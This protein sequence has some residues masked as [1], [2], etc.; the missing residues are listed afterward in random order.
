MYQ[1]SSIKGR[2]GHRDTHLVAVIRGHY[3]GKQ[4][5]KPNTEAVLM[6]AFNTKIELLSNL[7]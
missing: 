3:A 2:I 6:E 5:F 1:A 4:V 7:N